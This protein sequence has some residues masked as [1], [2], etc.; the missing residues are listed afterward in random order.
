MA[1]VLLL[2]RGWPYDIHSFVDVVPLLTAAGYRVIVPDLRGY[3][4]TRFRSSDAMRN[5]QPAAMA[6]APSRS[7]TPQHHVPA[8]AG[9]PPVP[10]HVDGSMR[11]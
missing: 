5:A 8:G 2:L 10:L 1:G 6:M 9:R 7:R 3:G 4:T 11:W